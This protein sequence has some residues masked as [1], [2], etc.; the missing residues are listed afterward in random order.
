MIPHLFSEISN[1]SSEI[2]LFSQL[3][4]VQLSP[5]L[6]LFPSVEGSGFTLAFSI[7]PL[8]FFS[9]LSAPSANTFG[10]WLACAV[11]ALSILAL[12]KQFIRK[13]PIEA[14]FLT[15][16]EFNEFRDKVETNFNSLRDRIDH[17]HEALAT[18]L[19]SITTRLHDVSSLVARLDERTK[20]SQTISHETSTPNKKDNL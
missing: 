11:A 12:G 18:K 5:L 14:E 17:S 16:K 2:T 3:P 7:Q 8:A 15:K 6:S 4:P 1:L 20:L 9:Q 19:D 10:A 13:T